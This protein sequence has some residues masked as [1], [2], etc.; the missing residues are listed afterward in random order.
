MSVYLYF[1]IYSKQKKNNRNIAMKRQSTRHSC[2][3]SPKRRM[4]NSDLRWIYV[5][6]VFQEDV[7]STIISILGYIVHN[8]SQARVLIDV[9][10][11]RPFLY[12]R[13]H[14]TMNISM[15][16][17]NIKRRFPV[18]I[19]REECVDGKPMI[20]FQKDASSYVKFTLNCEYDR[21]ILTRIIK[22]APIS[23]I[24]E[25]HISTLIRFSTMTGVIEGGWFA[26][27]GCI[28][29]EKFT[30]DRTKIQTRIAKYV[31]NRTGG[32][33]LC[34]LIRSDY[35][36]HATITAPSGVFEPIMTIGSFR[37]IFQNVY[38]DN[39]KPPT[40]PFARWTPL[41]QKE[42]GISQGSG[43]ICA[44]PMPV[45]SICVTVRHYG[46]L[47]GI[48]IGEDKYLI[49]TSTKF[50]VMDDLRE[51]GVVVISL[52]Q[53]GILAPKWLMKNSRSGRVEEK[54]NRR[55]A[56][57]L[58]EF[59][60]LM[61]TLDMIV[62]FRILDP[63]ADESLIYAMQRLFLFEVRNY[64]AGTM[65]SKKIAPMLSGGKN[66]FVL[67]TCVDLLCYA[68]RDLSKNVPSAS[69]KDLYESIMTPAKAGSWT[70]LVCR[71]ESPLSYEVAMTYAQNMFS[72]VDHESLIL[73]TLTR[74]SNWGISMDSVWYI[75]MPQ[76]MQQ[77]M[78]RQLS[79]M[80]DIGLYIVGAYT[81]NAWE[82]RNTRFEDPNDLSRGGRILLTPHPL[83]GV[84][85]FTL[86]FKAFFPS[87]VIGA[88]LGFTNIVYSDHELSTDY[89]TAETGGVIV[90]FHHP[91]SNDL[92]LP[93]LLRDLMRKRN[94]IT[95]SGSHQRAEN[96]AV[97]LLMNA[98]VGCLAFRGK[99]VF[100]CPAI[101]EIVRWVS[102][103]LFDTA[104]R[105]V[106]DDA[107]MFYD[108]DLGFIVREKGYH[109]LKKI[110]NFEVVGGHT[111]GFDVVAMDTKQPSGNDDGIAFLDLSNYAGK[112]SNLLSEYVMDMINGEST[113][114]KGLEC[115]WADKPILQVERV[116]SR[117]IY[118]SRTTKVWVPFDGPPNVVI[119]KGTLDKQ[120]RHCDI[121]RKIYK[122][123]LSQILLDTSACMDVDAWLCE[124]DRLASAS[125]LSGFVEYHRAT[126]ARQETKYSTSS[127][128]FIA[129]M[130]GVGQRTMNV[131]IP[132]VD[133]HVPVL[134]VRSDR[135]D[136]RRTICDMKAFPLHRDSFD[137]SKH[138]VVRSRYRKELRKNLVKLL[139]RITEG[140]VV[141]QV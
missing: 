24:Y 46:V 139:D 108:N 38:G 89:I 141:R 21:R 32:Q 14:N 56:A 45:D 92:P 123:V 19:F 55:E 35:I 132:S 137:P 85:G 91:G 119:S 75:G 70:G 6:K 136:A 112:L 121:V 5:T 86:D 99:F 107:G 43:D 109:D 71:D 122:D 72:I 106:R 8:G 40:R 9:Y 60:K 37:Y 130:I 125:P 13:P 140:S 111:D 57:M 96:T 80:S 26:L 49:T 31:L 74:A 82:N 101:G 98:I 1:F 41:L 118:V 90:G 93:L 114:L 94:A 62:G 30:E 44:V 77:A 63:L 48:L 131:P 104:V 28:V 113:G 27:S 68:K 103:N 76:V 129:K 47:S 133:Q 34:G 79:K 105:I 73:K 61:S 102:R 69:F 58:G 95:G 54:E 84:S 97:K 36:S 10:G 52:A 17:M 127:H 18:P 39:E 115:V 65:R 59:M 22:N 64:M 25:T 2:D 11:Q 138:T 78:Y 117:I 50:A 23:N 126:K 116:F 134:W 33:F 135:S 7:R 20:G 51:K 3:T 42:W 124:F 100:K 29:D 87:I 12:F 81:E 120:L 110:A 67:T 4:V 88:G 83:I 66:P 15:Q 16:I 53:G 128:D